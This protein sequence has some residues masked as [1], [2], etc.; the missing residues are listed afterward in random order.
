[1]NENSYLLDTDE[2][3]NVCTRCTKY[4]KCSTCSY[5]T[6]C[7]NYCLGG[8]ES[9]EPKSQNIVHDKSSILCCTFGI[10]TLVIIVMMISIRASYVSSLQYITNNT[11]KL[12][13]DDYFYSLLDKYPIKLNNNLLMQNVA[14]NAE[15]H[16][17][18][19]NGYGENMNY[20]FKNYTW[21]SLHARG[22]VGESDRKYMYPRY[23]HISQGYL[24]DCWLASVIS[25]IFTDTT[26]SI[27]NSIIS[28]SHT[29]KGNNIYKFNY[30]DWN[31]SKRQS[32]YFDDWVPFNYIE[33]KYIPL[34]GADLTGDNDP[35]PSLIEKGM[36]FIF[37]GYQNINGNEPNIGWYM[38]T[39][40]TTL[41][42]N[43][44][45][46]IDKPK[47][48]AT[49]KDIIHYMV[50]SDSN[51]RLGCLGI[52]LYGDPNNY[53][54]ENDTDV[55]QVLDKKQ[56][57]LDMYSRLNLDYNHEY[58]ILK[59]FNLERV[60][61]SSPKMYFMLRNPHGLKAAMIYNSYYHLVN[62][63]IN[64]TDQFKNMHDYK[65]LVQFL[66]A[67]HKYEYLQ[68]LAY[69]DILKLNGDITI[70]SY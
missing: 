44:E 17:D 21:V 20:I 10:I 35:I 67:A 64:E 37:G 47:G 22:Y 3:S 2:V 63:L 42:A 19:T 14:S 4:V 11:G 9:D 23:S 54:V 65:V 16:N 51:I 45:T 48:H 5:S 40:K 58:S 62:N 8:Y 26:G 34:F 43:L 56:Y 69:R 49:K 60:N 39:G 36:A 28:Y 1:M 24:G 50:N 27:V 32:I 31:S 55:A 13:D 38:L 6:Y 52:D 12:L 61:E 18:I 29:D 59:L 70:F 7:P 33:N 68:L 53:D 30:F 66:N 41:I 57:Y 15:L 25:V 46:E